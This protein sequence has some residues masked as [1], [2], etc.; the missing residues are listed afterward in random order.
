MISRIAILLLMALLSCPLHTVWSQTVIR[1]AENGTDAPQCLYNNFGN[2]T[3]PE[4]MACASLNYAFSHVKNNTY[5]F[6][7]C[8]YHPLHPF[9]GNTPFWQLENI[10]LR[11]MCPWEFNAT[12]VCTA[13]NNL[14]FY[15]STAVTV[16]G[17]D[18][19]NCGPGEPVEEVPIRPSSLYFHACRDVTL[20]D[21]GVI[22]GSGRGIAFYNNGHQ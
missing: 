22:L 15:Q 11:S 7:D 4:G 17:L 5:Y 20:V 1:V 2:W 14:L 8:G 12:I 21:V 13:K 16:S 10:Q 6:I 18:F 3:T 19:R 9:Q